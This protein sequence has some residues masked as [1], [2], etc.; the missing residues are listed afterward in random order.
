M[1]NEIETP[2]NTNSHRSQVFLC[3]FVVLASVLNAA[4][5]PAIDWF[6]FSIE[7]VNLIF[8]FLGFITGEACVAAILSGLTG[9]TFHTGFF[10]GVVIAS[11]WFLGFAVGAWFVEGYERLEFVGTSAVVGISTL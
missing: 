6:D 4:V 5:I 11:L 10:L 8:A 2:A 7:E 9:R 3:V 1:Q